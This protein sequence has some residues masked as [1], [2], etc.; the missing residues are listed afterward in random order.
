VLQFWR[1]Q[2]AAGRKKKVRGIEKESK[3]HT[4]R[5]EKR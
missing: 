3:M 1:L 2:F 4:G 5:P